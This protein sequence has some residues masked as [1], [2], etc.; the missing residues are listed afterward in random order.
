MITTWGIWQGISQLLQTLH[1]IAV[2]HK[3]E[4]ANVATRWVLQRPEVGAVIVGTRL[5]VSSKLNAIVQAFTFPVSGEEVAM[6]EE[7]ALGYDRGKPLKLYMHIG[8]CGQEYR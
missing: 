7:V 6:I 3:V 2:S 8:D 1:R 4:M 5:G